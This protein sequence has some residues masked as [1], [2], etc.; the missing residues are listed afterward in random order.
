MSFH[1]PPSAKRPKKL[2]RDQLARQHQRQLEIAIKRARA[3]ELQ[4]RGPLV[5]RRPPRTDAEVAQVRAVCLEKAKLEGYTG[6][7]RRSR[8]Q[9]I[10]DEIVAEA[11][12]QVR[13][14]T[15]LDRIIVP[16][17]P[18]DDTSRGPGGIIILPGGSG[19]VR[20]P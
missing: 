1:L 8:A 3:L 16:A 7:R 14:V 13:M 18:K 4:R 17:Q 2:S 6:K 19:L 11:Q 5:L 20:P 10:Y 9:A 12:H 15:A